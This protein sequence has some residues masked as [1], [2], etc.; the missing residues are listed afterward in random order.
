MAG[1]GWLGWISR[2]G[3][4]EPSAPWVFT[5]TL[6]LVGFRGGRNGR[7]YGLLHDTPY[8]IMSYARFG[9][10]GSFF[11]ICF[12]EIPWYILTRHGAVSDGGMS[13]YMSLLFYTTRTHCIGRRRKGGRQSLLSAH[14]VGCRGKLRGGVGE[15]FGGQA[16]NGGNGAVVDVCDIADCVLRVPNEFDRIRRR[17]RG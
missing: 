1:L 8:T 9:A 2:S 16:W 13:M 10:F 5:G 4:S 6:G 15:N 12:H 3:P 17:G 7:G 11:R 14:G